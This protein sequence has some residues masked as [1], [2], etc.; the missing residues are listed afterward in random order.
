M[1]W[2]TS[3]KLEHPLQ[4]RGHGPRRWATPAGC[5]LVAHQPPEV[6]WSCSGRICP[7][8]PGSRGAAPP[9]RASPKR[10]RARHSP[11]LLATHPVL[12]LL[13]DCREQRRRPGSGVLALEPRN[14]T[15]EQWERPGKSLTLQSAEVFDSL[16]FLFL[17][18]GTGLDAFD[19]LVH[20]GRTDAALRRRG[21][22]GARVAGSRARRGRPT[23]RSS[24]RSCRCR[25]AAARRAYAQQRNF[26]KNV[27]GHASSA[28]PPSRRRTR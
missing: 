23:P 26:G 21:R 11:T 6:S 18:R 8:H 2:R 22:A 1:S 25:R 19:P 15:G 5:P 14:R 16:R 4:R 28:T 10:A 27:P 12:R 3:Q 20:L 9:R 13:P 24:R 17:L 7:G